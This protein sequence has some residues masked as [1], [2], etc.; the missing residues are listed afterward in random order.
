MVSVLIVLNTAMKYILGDENEAVHFSLVWGDPG[1]Y[2]KHLQSLDILSQYHTM[3]NEVD[4]SY[5]EP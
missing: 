4:F 1:E 2:M 5:T 3:N